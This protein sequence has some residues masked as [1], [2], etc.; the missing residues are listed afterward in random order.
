MN[1]EDWKN[2]ATIAGIVVAVATYI[3]NSYFQFRNK[4]I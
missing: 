4:R 1:L 3:T 2:V